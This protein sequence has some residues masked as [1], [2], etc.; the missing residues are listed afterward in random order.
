MNSLR[1]SVLLSLLALACGGTSPSA[2]PAQSAPVAHAGADQAVTS[3]AT[4]VTV[5]LAGSAS[6]VPAGLAVT[7][8]WTQASGPVVAL[9]SAA[10]ASPTFSAP[11]VLAGQSAVTL[12]FALTVNSAA[13]TSAPASVI[14]T[15]NPV[16]SPNLAPPPGT[17]PPAVADPNTPAPG[18]TGSAGPKSGRFEVGAPLGLYLVDPAKGEASVQGLVNVTYGPTSAGGIPPDGTTVTMNGVALLKDPALNGAFWRLDPAGPQPVTGSGG[19][20]VLV[21]TLP[22][23]GQ[24][25]PDVRTMVLPC[26]NDVVVTSTPAIGSALVPAAPLHL[27]SAAD[28]TLNVGNW[29]PLVGAVPQALLYG[30]DPATRA[31]SPLSGSSVTFIHTPGALNVDVPVTT[32]TAPAYLIDLRWPGQGFLDGQT[33]GFCGLAKRWTYTR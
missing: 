28:I 17:P 27:A 21:A 32:T 7:Y 11:T 14:V 13:G 2:P 1:I 24:A 5:T 10:A 8:Q 4:T 25:K 16:G 22:I 18:A 19:Q 33:G 6:G 29:V 3:A 12:V 9:S 26:P 30:Y 20:L 15:V 23:P 31:L